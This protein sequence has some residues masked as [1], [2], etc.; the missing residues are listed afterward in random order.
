MSYNSLDLHH[1]VVLYVKNDGAKRSASHH[2]K[3]SLGCDN[4]WYKLANEAIT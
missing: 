4:D 3:I 1:R 2:C